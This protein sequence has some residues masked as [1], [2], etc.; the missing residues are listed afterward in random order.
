[1]LAG[2][3]LVSYVLRT[4]ISVAAKFMMP[5]LGLSEVQMGWVFSSFMLG[6]AIF[7]IPAGLLGDRKGPRLVLALAALLWSATTLLTGL[8]PG[9]ILT[10][11][12]GALVS[13][14]MVRF[15]L[16]AAEAATYP[17]ASRAVATWMP[18]AERAFANSIVIAG[19][20]V[21]LVFTPPLIAWLMVTRGW[22]ETFYVTSVLGLMMAFLWWRY[23]TDQPEKHTKVGQA[24]LKL[25]NTGKNAG[26]TEGAQA[27]YASWWGLLRNRN[28]GLICLSY[29]LDSFVLFIFIFWFYLYLVN[30][31]GFS[32]LKGGVFNSLP[33]VFGMVM[34]PAS[35]RLCDYL[36]VRLGRNQGRRLLATGCLTFS[37][38]LLM[39]GAKA[40]EPYL[41]I[42][43]L[44]LSVGF[45]MSTEGPFWASS[46][47]VAGPHAGTAGGI[48]NTAGNAGGVVSTAIAPILVQQFGWFATFAF[49]SALAVLAGLIWLFIRVDQTAD[50]NVADRVEGLNASASSETGR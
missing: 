6:Y 23:A 24:E 35:G 50:E 7:Q 44:S 40:A 46:I 43:C 37:A 25:I 1:M 38:V 15:T 31:R 32:L 39:V 14:M 10:S 30:E 8:I 45:L 12:I 49:C 26:K 2:F 13:L 41:A 19:S 22:R 47:D 9:L 3:S 5:E 20:T 16:G 29:F 42:V 11:S 4:N 34:I 28:L 21:G 27:R 36:S 17:V 48:M 33:Y 18:V